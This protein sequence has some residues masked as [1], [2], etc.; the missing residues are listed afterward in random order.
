MKVRFKRT[1]IYEDGEFKQGEI[2]DVEKK[3]ADRFAEYIEVVKIE[4]DTD[5]VKKTDEGKEKVEK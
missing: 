3:I 2:Y 4:T 1:I 5:K